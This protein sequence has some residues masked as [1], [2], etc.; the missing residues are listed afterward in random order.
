MWGVRTGELLGQLRAHT[1]PV[2]SCHLLGTR[3]VSGSTALRASIRELMIVQTAPFF[4]IL[5]AMRTPPK[6]CRVSLHRPRGIAT[7]PCGKFALATKGL[8]M[9]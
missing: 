1:R 9:V 2:T 3:A 6:P 8:L 4:S 7:Q 5:T